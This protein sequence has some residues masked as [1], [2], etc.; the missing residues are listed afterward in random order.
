[1]NKFFLFLLAVPLL[2][3]CS[4]ILSNIAGL[5][6]KKA[7]DEKTILLLSKENNIPTEDSFQLDTL[8]FSFLSVVYNASQRNNHYQPLQALYYDKEGLL[9]VFIVNCYAGGFPNLKWNRNHALETFLPKQQ[10]PVDSVLHL[11]LHLQFLKPMAGAKKIS[12]SYNDYTLVVYWSRFMGRQSTRFIK[13]IQKN[14][15]LA[16]GKKVRVV[17]VN[18]DNFFAKVV[19]P[20]PSPYHY[21]K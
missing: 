8:Y 13:A 21:Q 5:N 17:Y 4:K 15:K 9:C 7:V 20:S 11:N 18:N 3:G 6:E 12:A 1:M 2:S 10:A 14:S 16:Q 19:K